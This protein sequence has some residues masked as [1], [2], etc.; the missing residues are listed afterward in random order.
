[1]LSKNLQFALITHSPKNKIKCPNYTRNHSI[2]IKKRS[3]KQQ[4]K[5]RLLCK[6]LYNV[7]TISTYQN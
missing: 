5:S 3:K 7:F 4:V 1:M 2:V 6:M